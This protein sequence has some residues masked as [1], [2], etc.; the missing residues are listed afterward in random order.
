MTNK[1][2]K[3]TFIL[4]LNYIFFTFFRTNLDPDARFSSL[5]TTSTMQ[6]QNNTLFRAAGEKQSHP[7]YFRFRGVMENV[8]E[9]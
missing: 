8:T 4:T 1:R 6:K 2:Q 9:T 7:Q 3:S 5:E